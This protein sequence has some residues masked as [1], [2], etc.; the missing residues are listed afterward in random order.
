MSANIPLVKMPSGHSIPVI[1]LGT[2][3]TTDREVVKTSIS[4]ALDAGYR[5]IDTAHI[6]QNEA[7]IG[8]ALKVKFAEGG[9]KREDVFITTKLWGTE[10]HP[11]DVRPACGESLRKLQLSYVDLYY[12]HWPVHLLRQGE[13]RGPFTLEDTWR[14]MEKLVDAGLVRSIG[15][16]NF[17]KAQIDRIMAIARIKPA[18]LQIESS[19]VFLNEKLIKYAQLI[20]LPVTAYAP[21]GSPGTS[22]DYANPL[23]LPCVLDIAKAHGK[24]PAQVLVRHALQRQLVVIPKSTSP[25]RILE[26][27]KVFD[28]ELSPVEMEALNNAEP[29]QCRRFG[30]RAWSKLPEYPFDDEL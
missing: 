13:S 6:Y 29:N 16:S 15:I 7:D 28:F 10:H 5:H 30:L 17:N 26:N 2:F 20:G 3:K 14:E 4:A 27:I 22:P 19:V 9:I 23:E 24:S 25:K 11:M 8:E 18:M 21:F 1:G 12:V